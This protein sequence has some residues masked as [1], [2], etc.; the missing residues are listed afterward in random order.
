MTLAQ[1]LTA[2]KPGVLAVPLNE[3]GK[4][5]FKLD[6]LAPANGFAHLN[7]HDALADVE[8]TI[9]LVRLIR[10]RAPNEWQ[11]AIAHSVKANVVEFVA[12]EPAFVLTECYF[13]RPF[14]FPLTRIG[15][16]SENAGTIFAL[17]LRADIAALRSLS[18]QDLVTR[19]SRSPRIVRAI[20]ANAG[21]VMSRVD[22]GESFA[23]VSHQ[24]W[25]DRANVVQGDRDLC[26]RLVAAA[27][28]KPEYRA[29]HHVEEQIYSA[30]PTRADEACMRNFHRVEWEDRLAIIDQFADHRL[31]HLGARLVSAHRPDL[32]NDEQ[33]DYYKRWMA[34]RLHSN[35]VGVPWRTVDKAITEIEAL[36]PDDK[37]GRSPIVDGLHRHL[38]TIRS[39]AAS[40]A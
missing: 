29:S 32:L 4:P 25:K 13:N 31:A 5:T 38:K 12:R 37:H 7:A 35:D 20:R 2:L 16:A 19:I 28:A 9:H 18:D 36:S 15:I 14:Q 33:A 8:A 40:S 23:G 3:K 6:R 39:F 10:E 22:E 21:P 27:T 34:D 1:A 24:E 11:R 26:E 30:F 17:D